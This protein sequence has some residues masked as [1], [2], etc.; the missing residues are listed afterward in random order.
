MMSAVSSTW[1]G[2]DSRVIA[3]R[4]SWDAMSLVSEEGSAVPFRNC[5]AVG[6]VAPNPKAL[7]HDVV[8]RGVSDA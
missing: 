5:R 1:I 3:W 2:A 7:M 8:A 6:V 4:K